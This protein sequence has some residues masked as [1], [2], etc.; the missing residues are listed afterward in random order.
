M[1]LDFWL[2][3]TVFST[4]ITHNLARMAHEAG[5]Y[6]ALWH[7]E[8]INCDSANHIIDIVKKGYEKLIENPAHYR[9]FDAENG[10]GTYDQFVPWIRDVLAALEA[11]PYAT[12]KT[13]T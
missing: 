2:E 8:R 10:W 5:I 6:E 4:N 1:S 9:Q 12:I 13:S 11:N 3:D 7:P